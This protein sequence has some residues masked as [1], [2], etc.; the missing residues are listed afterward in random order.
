MKH[1]AYILIAIHG[2]LFFWSFGGFLEM[3]LP[4]VAW[5]PF[6]NPEFPNWVLVMHWGSVLFAS[7][8]FL[9]GYFA[10]WKNTPMMMVV[11]YG[12]MMT[13]C[14]IETFG[15]MTNKTKYLAMGGEFFAYAGILALLFKSQ[16]FIDRFSKA[17]QKEN[18]L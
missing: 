8:I 14:I 17:W 2:I 7:L 18:P 12:I 15:F 4:A 5:K 13:V 3:I 9:Y 1:I 10:K 11:A 6:T 16:Y